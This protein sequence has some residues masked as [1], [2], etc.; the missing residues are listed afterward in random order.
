M[1]LQRG[2]IILPSAMTLA[3]LFFGLWAVVSASRGQFMIAAWLIVW[4]AIFDTVDGRVARYTQ[5]GSRFGEELDSLVDAISFGVA[6]ALI[7]YHLF[8]TDGTWGWVACFF[9]VTC[10]VIRLA[11]FNVEQAGHA[12]VVFHGLPSPSA[13]ITLATYYPFSRTDFFQQNLADWRW[14]SIMIGIMVVLGFLMMS[15]V[16]YAVMPKI[17]LSSRRGLINFAFI[18]TMIVLA[19]AIPSLYFFPAA[20]LYVSYAVLK[21]L[22]LGFAERLPER[23]PLLDAE[24]WDE[25]GAEMRDIDYAEITPHRRFRLPGYRRRRRERR[26]GQERRGRKGDRPQDEAS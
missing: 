26:S 22:V 24:D 19:V 25:A 18:L 6:P 11:R 23:D 15:H 7:I 4:A 1:R 17:S 16:P 9:Y 10:A 2:V 8:L 14:P 21:A 20:M 5:T 13:G 3:N 12:K